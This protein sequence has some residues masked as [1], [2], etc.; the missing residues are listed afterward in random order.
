MSIKV[1]ARNLRAISSVDYALNLGVRPSVWDW[2]IASFPG[3]L[4]QVLLPQ[5]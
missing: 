3:L 4:S 1:L 5:L 2:A